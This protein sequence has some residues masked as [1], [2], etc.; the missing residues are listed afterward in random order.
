MK[1]KDVIDREELLSLV[2]GDM[3]LLCELI[4]LFMEG[5]Q[6]HMSD[7]ETA[8]IKKDSSGLYHSAHA[9]KGSVGNFVS[10]EPFNMAF[11]LEKMGKDEDFS[12]SIKAYKT[13]EEEIDIFRQNLELVKE[14]GFF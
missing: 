4:D 5:C 14:N 11:E 9:L 2:D 10:N 8:I 1:I 3:E 6:K 12:D 13:L 7:I